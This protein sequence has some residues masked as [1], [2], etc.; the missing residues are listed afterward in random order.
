LVLSP[1]AR[2]ARAIAG[3]TRRSRTLQ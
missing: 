2:I 3:R 1:L